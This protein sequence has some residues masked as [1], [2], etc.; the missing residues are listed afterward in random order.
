MW[1]PVLLGAAVCYFQKLIG[2]S[3]PRDFLENPIV[4][5][6]VALLP[7]ALLT[8]LVAVQTVANKQSLTI[9]ARLPAFAVAVAAMRL[10]RSFIE[11]V[12]SA[13]LTAA[14]IRHFDLLT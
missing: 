14:L 13:A 1:I 7:V 8:A 12:L 6:I 9:D 2:A 5:K 10:K 3:L 4:K 11:V